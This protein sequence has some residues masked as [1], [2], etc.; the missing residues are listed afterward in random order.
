MARVGSTQLT[1]VLSS[2]GSCLHQLDSPGQKVISRYC[3]LNMETAENLYTTIH[4]PVSKADKRSTKAL[5]KAFFKKSTGGWHLSL[6]QSSS[7][8]VAMSLR[9]CTSSPSP[10]DCTTLKNTYFTKE[11]LE[12]R[13]ALKFMQDWGLKNFVF[14]VVKVVFY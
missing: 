11:N 13:K 1:A 14:S 10:Q 3:S 4:S 6:S 8:A 7:S 5:R 9:R 12:F 2:K